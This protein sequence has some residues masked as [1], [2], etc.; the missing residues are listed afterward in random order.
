VNGVGV[1]VFGLWLAQA[2]LSFMP[3]P[4]TKQLGLQDARQKRRHIE[5][6]VQYR[7]M[8]ACS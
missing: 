3:C 7:E 5:I 1:E 4:A 2:L 8:E 6:C